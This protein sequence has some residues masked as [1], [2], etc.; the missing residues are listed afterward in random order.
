MSLQHLQ[1]NFTLGFFNPTKEYEVEEVKEIVSRKKDDQAL[2]VGTIPLFG[3]QIKSLIV[4]GSGSE[5]YLEADL[6]VCFLQKFAKLVNKTVTIIPATISH[7]IKNYEQQKLYKVTRYWKRI[8]SHSYIIVPLHV[9]Y[10]H[11]AI[12][13]ADTTKG[14]IF[15]S[16]A[17]HKSAWKVMEPIHHLLQHYGLARDQLE[18]V[19]PLELQQDGINCGVYA[20]WYS[21]NVLSDSENPLDIKAAQLDTYR[22]YMCNTILSPTDH[23]VTLNTYTKIYVPDFY[24]ESRQQAITIDRSIRQVLKRLDEH[25]LE[26]AWE[27]L[28]QAVEQEPHIA[29][30]WAKNSQDPCAPSRFY[31]HRRKN[32]HK[33]MHCAGLDP[34]ELSRG[35]VKRGGKR[36]QKKKRKA[37]EKKTKES[38][39]N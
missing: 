37:Q 14:R 33:I 19:Q 32:Y 7:F 39:K 8:P 30:L 13:V 20:V 21:A 31:W 23:I 6:M 10:G 29:E 35:P 15:C 5:N 25:N 24:F 26:R 22:R 34:K 1:S 3:S 12:Y 9:H 27:L 36:E 16:F 18:F 38:Q 2:Q 17:D 11:W 28:K 4:P